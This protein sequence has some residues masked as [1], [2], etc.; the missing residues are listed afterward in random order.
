MAENSGAESAWIEPAALLRLV[1]RDA[2][3]RGDEPPRDVI[4]RE[5]SMLIPVSPPGTP[6]LDLD[7]YRVRRNRWAADK[8]PNVTGMQEF[9]EM[10]ETLT[11]PSRA[12][13]VR[14]KRATYTF[15]LNASMT[16]VLGAAAVDPPSKATR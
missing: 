7:T 8:G 12:A 6:P 9:V 3:V 15:L 1:E 14:G 5:P 13:V 4:M 11:T 10:L 2:S 16:R